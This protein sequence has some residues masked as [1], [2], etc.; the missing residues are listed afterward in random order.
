MEIRADLEPLRKL[1]RDSARVKI[2]TSH[3]P[4]VDTVI[5]ALALRTVLLRHNKEVRL[6]LPDSTEEAQAYLAG[7]EGVVTELT[8]RRTTVKIALKDKGLHKLSYEQKG[9]FLQLYLAAKQGVVMP[10]DVTV[11]VE[12]EWADL[13]FTIGLADPVSLQDWGGEWITEVKQSATIVN[14]DNHSDNKRYGGMN[15]VDPNDLS[16]SVLMYKTLRDAGFEIDAVSAQLLLRA[17]REVTAG[18]TSK[19]NREVFNVAGELYA[20]T[21]IFEITRPSDKGGVDTVQ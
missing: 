10:E 14:L 20:L 2:I 12:P 15:L 8:P 7:V 21:E 4:S 1:V 19:L 18:F 16:V 9:E 11:A 6:F 13:I 17:I 5:A 3:A